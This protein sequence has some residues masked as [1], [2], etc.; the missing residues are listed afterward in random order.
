MRALNYSALGDSGVATAMGVLLDSLTFG[1]QSIV[2]ARVLE[3][4]GASDWNESATLVAVQARE[5][6]R[7]ML[8]G[9]QGVR[10]PGFS[11]ML[12]IPAEDPSLRLE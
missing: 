4:K 6:V 7:C 9:S 8:T 3:S 1:V 5:V 10:R 12:P 11:L 2:Q